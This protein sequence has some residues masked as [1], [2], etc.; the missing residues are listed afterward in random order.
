MKAWLKM[1]T[2]SFVGAFIALILFEYYGFGLV[3]PQKP[4][5]K[6]Q[7]NVVNHSTHLKSAQHLAASVK[8]GHQIVGKDLHQVAGL[9]LEAAAALVVVKVLTVLA[10]A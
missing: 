9:S 4:Y 8:G 2:A 3:S 7:N 5:D 1:A 10:S 6:H